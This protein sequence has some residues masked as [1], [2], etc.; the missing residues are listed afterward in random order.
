MFG[1]H[2]TLDLYHCNKEKLND[3]KLITKLL[4]DFPEF[5]GMHRI[6]EPQVTVHHGKP[7]SFDRGGISAFVLLAESHV[8]IHTFP[9][10][11][12]ASVDIFSCKEFDLDKAQDF[13]MK[14][15]EAKE[16]EKNL[17]MR[18]K[19]YVKHY[20]RNISKSHKIVQKERKKLLR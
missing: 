13:L 6:S 1:P 7:E 18:G 9:S 2:L 14:T 10:D 17:I 16:A 15:F 20:P 3:A 4:V 11:K 12:F 19:N 5:I 8:S